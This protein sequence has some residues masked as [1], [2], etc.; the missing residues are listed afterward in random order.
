VAGRLVP[1]QSFLPYP[2]NA[3]SAEVLDDRRLGKQRVECLQILSVLTGLRAPWAPGATTGPVERYVPKGWTNHPAVRMW[4][5]H[6]DA[7]V[8]YTLEVC[9][10]WE[11]RGHRDTVAPKV[12][13]IAARHAADS[14]SAGST[15]HPE[16]WGRAELHES[17]RSNLLRKDEEHYR[18]Y[19]P[20]TPADLPY[21]WPV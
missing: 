4:R 18:R 7:L 3:R 20:Q 11:R 12:R 6:V 2:D 15:G 9:A 13:A 14:P 21:H 1:V 16:W 8:A 5:G 17:H 10:E 19:F